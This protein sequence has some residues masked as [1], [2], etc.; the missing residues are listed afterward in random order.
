M[1]SFPCPCLLTPSSTNSLSMSCWKLLPL[2]YPYL[3]LYCPLSLVPTF[4]Q[5]NLPFL[6]TELQDTSFFLYPYF[7]ALICLYCPLSLAPASLPRA[8]LIPYHFV[9]GYFSPL[10]YPYFTALIC[11]YCPLS[12]APAFLHR[13]LAIP[14]H[15][16]A[17]YFSTFFTPISQ[18]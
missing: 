11:F 5:Q 4:L 13:A 12:F 7:T 16:V 17:G 15:S 1:S 10:L 2:L 18:P 14:Y 8:L 6:S 9:A 3:S